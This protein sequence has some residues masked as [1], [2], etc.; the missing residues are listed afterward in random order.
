MVQV[1]NAT[2]SIYSAN[3]GGYEYL[4]TEIYGYAYEQGIDRVYI[5]GLKDR[6]ALTET[7]KQESWLGLTSVTPANL[8][9]GLAYDEATGTEGGLCQY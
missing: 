1:S 9:P 3:E 5:K 7:A 8:V 4:A 6:I 2:L